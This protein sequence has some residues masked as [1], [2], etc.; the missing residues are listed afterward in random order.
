MKR[1]AAGPAPG[2]GFDGTSAIQ[3]HM[4]NT[5]MTDPEVLELRYPVRQVLSASGVV[6]AARANGAAATGRCGA[7]AFW[8]R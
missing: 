4:T 7:S 5:R 6:R 8:S 1:S 2:P 3:T